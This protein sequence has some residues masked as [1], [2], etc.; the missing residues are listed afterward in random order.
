MKLFAFI[1]AN[2]FRIEVKASNP[3]AAYNKLKSIPMFNNCEVYG[4]IT[5][6]YYEHPKN[7]K[8]YGFVDVTNI[9]NLGA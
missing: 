7:G 6:S 5:N 1:T 3:K 8:S 9:K 4:K 2:S